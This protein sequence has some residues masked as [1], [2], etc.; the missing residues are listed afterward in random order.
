MPVWR[1]F[2]SISFPLLYVIYILYGVSY[3][4]VIFAI[5]V[6][7]VNLIQRRPVRIVFFNPAQLIVSFFLS[8]ILLFHAI[9]ILEKFTDSEIMLGL[10]QYSMLLALFLLFNNL[11]V[12]MVL[13]IRPQPYPFKIWLQKSITEGLSG[14]VSLLYGFLLY[15]IGQDRGEIDIFS[16]FFFFSPLV[17]LAL[18]SSVIVRLRKERKRLKALFNI[19]N[20]L[21]QMLPTQKWLS[22]LKESF[23]DFMNVDALL[24][25]VKE[26]GEWQLAIKDG[27]VRKNAETTS[28]LLSSFDEVKSPLIFDNRKKGF[29]PADSFFEKDI[30]SAVYSPLVID[31]ETVGMFFVGRSRTRSFEDEDIRSIAT[32]SNQLAVILKTKMLFN[33]KEKRIVLE[34]RNRIAREIHDGLAQTLAGAVMK[35]DTAGKKIAKQPQVTAMLVKES[36]LGLRESLK[37]VRASIYALRPYPT[38]RTGLKMAIANKIEAVRKDHG[39][40]IHFEVRGHEEELSPMAEKVLFDTFKESIQ[41]AVKH[42]NADK[43]EVLL[44]YQSEHILLKIKD[45]GKGFSL[46]QAMLKARTQPHFGILQMNDA[47]D[48]INASLQID[49]HEG[50][51]TE[52]TIIVPKMGFEGGSQIDQADAGG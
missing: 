5:A 43:L 34:E 40:I 13:V 45:N 25:W 18:L 1:G 20:E 36:I 14:L 26:G 16:Y 47:A 17:G 12:D 8:H 4:L 31:N 29:G 37:E 22:K 9:P 46:F 7:T 23:Q 48:K 10:A 35:L 15:F 49:S 50:S 44:S 28:N 39:K 19:T 32:L 11:I 2:T 38:E 51:G 30:K 33:E 41:N 6:L 24:L 21:N 27:H 42:S 52:V 3:T